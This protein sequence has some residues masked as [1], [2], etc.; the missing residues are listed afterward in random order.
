MPMRIFRS[1]WFVLQTVVKNFSEQIGIDEGAS[2]GI[3]LGQDLLLFEL[4]ESFA[5]L[6]TGFDRG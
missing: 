3:P 1:A 5:L 6:N 4:V 2:P